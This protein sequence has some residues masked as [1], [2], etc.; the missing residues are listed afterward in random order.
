MSHL[1][2]HGD[3]FREDGDSLESWLAGGGIIAVW[4]PRINCSSRHYYGRLARR[5]G[6]CSCTV[7]SAS[8]AS[9][10]RVRH[11]TFASASKRSGRHM[12][13]SYLRSHTNPFSFNLPPTGH[14]SC[15]A[16]SGRWLKLGITHPYSNLPICGR[17]GTP[18]VSPQ[19]FRKDQALRNC[20]VFCCSLAGSQ[21][22][23]LLAIVALTGEDG[24]FL[25]PQDASTSQRHTQLLTVGFSL[26]QSPSAGG[27]AEP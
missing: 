7:D 10:S 20:L 13:E 14:D 16:T 2:D 3:R 26:H 25:C 19:C 11:G 15:R 23:T 22:R 1:L 6:F 12:F 21:P 18:P 5:V 24:P 17:W 4:V 8:Q 27:P 9:R